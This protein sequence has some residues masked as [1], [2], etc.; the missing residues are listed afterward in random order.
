MTSVKYFDSEMVGAAVLSGGAAG[1]LVA[2]LDE[3]LVTGRG[4][5]PCTVSVSG[6]IATAAVAGGHVFRAGV[7]V[8]MAGAAV[9]SINGEHRLTATTVGSVTFPAPGVADGAVAGSITIKLAPAGWSK[10]FSAANKAAYRSLDPSASGCYARVDDSGAGSTRYARLI[11]Y[12]SMTD[13]DTGSNP[14]PA[15]GVVAGGWAVFKSNV[16]DAAARKWIIVA[17][18]K[19][20]VILIAHHSL[21]LSDYLVAGW[22]DLVSDKAGDAYPFMTFGAL[23]VAQVV[24]STSG[25]DSLTAAG[26]TSCSLS[27][28][29]SQSGGSVQSRSIIPG[30]INAVSGYEGNP[31]GPSVVNNALYVCPIIIQEG[32]T[33]SAPIRGRWPG[34]YHL[35]HAVGSA[36]DSKAIVTGVDG[37]VGRSLMAVRF[38]TGQAA[39]VGRRFMVDITGPWD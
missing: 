9:T 15:G 37:L 27:R 5:M 17:D 6:G 32:V 30:A 23:D 2:I 24:N 20:V 29:Y 8:L 14:S 11:G 19:R 16:A 1:S 34:I 31:I 39:V 21:Y 38:G 25:S 28:P 33:S 35:P 22:G 4:L 12:D 36:Y 26:S 3:C 18:A 10:A 13:V 7:V